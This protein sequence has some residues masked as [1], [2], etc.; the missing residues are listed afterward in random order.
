MERNRPADAQ[1]L[2]DAAEVVREYS[3]RPDGL[4][5]MALVKMLQNA[6]D[7]IEAGEN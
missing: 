2:R 6:A 5:C 3:T 7:G 4:W 1:T